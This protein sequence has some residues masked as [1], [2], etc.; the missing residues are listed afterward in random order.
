MC[1]GR[2][3]GW[4]LLLL[5]D[6]TL[7]CVLCSWPQALKEFTVRPL[8]DQEPAPGLTLSHPVLDVLRKVGLKK[9]SFQRRSFEVP[10]IN[11]DRNAP[12]TACALGRQR[13]RSPTAHACI[14]PPFFFLPP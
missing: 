11:A 9:G 7:S 14:L 1:T 13:W 10:A 12:W 4:V 3:C 6:L 2:W 8:D 5:C